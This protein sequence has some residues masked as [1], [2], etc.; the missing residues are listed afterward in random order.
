MITRAILSLLKHNN[1]VNLPTLGAII[2]QQD[3][4]QTLF[5]NQ[6]IKYDD[7]LLSDYLAKIEMLTKEESK[8]AI[9]GFIENIQDGIHRN[10][11][12]EI[13]EIGIFCYVD[14]RLELINEKEFGRLP[15]IHRPI[16]TPEQVNAG[17]NYKE[18]LPAPDPEKEDE[19]LPEDADGE[20]NIDD[21]ILSSS[22]TTARS[23]ITDDGFEPAEGMRQARPTFIVSKVKLRRSSRPLKFI[24]ITIPLIVVGLML[25][26]LSLPMPGSDHT[27]AGSADSAGSVASDSISLTTPTSAR[28]PR[29]LSV[30]V[31]GLAEAAA[32]EESNLVYHVI[33]GAFRLEGNADKLVAE[34]LTRGHAV[35]KLGKRNGYYLVSYESTTD[36]WLAKKICKD[37]RAF[38]PE[39]W[40][41]KQE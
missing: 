17:D 9:R 33:I 36:V 22:I 37:L 28:S 23:E 1:R 39:V 6:F 7:G 12:F 2:K 14:N 29:S 38:Y 4:S 8:A 32:K 10:G 16:E 27:A 3:F 15:H 21:A 19:N 40:L 13:R 35:S 26:R 11:K 18:M 31:P 20:H 24:R 30:P 34:Q 25:F 5:F 41:D